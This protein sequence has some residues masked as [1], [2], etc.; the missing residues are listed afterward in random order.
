[1]T[2]LR[3]LFTRV[4]LDET[5][6]QILRGM[7]TALAPDAPPVLAQPRAGEAPPSR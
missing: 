1:M 7:L 6:V 2:R 3:R 4:A 5:E